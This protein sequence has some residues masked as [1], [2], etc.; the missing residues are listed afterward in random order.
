MKYLFTLL[1]LTSLLSNAQKD[2]IRLK[3]KNILIGTV[4]SF[5][6]GILVFSTN[7]SD[8]DFHIKFDHITS[9]YIHKKCI[10]TLTKSRR[11]FGLVRNIKPGIV[12]ITTNEHLVEVFK[13]SEITSFQEVSDER[14]KRY[15]GSIDIGYDFTKA[16]NKGQT[17]VNS[18]LGY[19][20][21]L[22]VSN[23][24]LDI[25]DSKQD[26][27]DDIK[28]TDSKID[29]RRLFSKTWYLIGELTFLSN[30][31]Q[32]LDARYT[33]NIG[34]GKLLASTPKLYLGLSSGI[35]YNVETYVDET[36]NKQST[37]A[38]ISVNFNMFKFEDISLTTDIKVS[39]T[40]SEWGRT[41]VDYNLT[42]KYDLPY[43]FYIKTAFTLNYD[44]EPAIVGNQ[45]DYIFSS[46]L[47]W[48]FNK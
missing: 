23:V 35:A 22:W 15:T 2:T 39:P 29:I 14:K 48:K 6:T 43:D 31:E 44:N 9:I 28:R 10:I 3:N 27:V 38:F 32:A 45:Y 19:V 13:I 5:K 37:E 1:L 17:T 42:L 26:D 16:Q 18:T 24:S 40:I 36:L 4:E 30:T 46:G 21:K 47:G 25:L 33:P 7:Y 8:K 41:R 20:G 34:M 11:R 12:A